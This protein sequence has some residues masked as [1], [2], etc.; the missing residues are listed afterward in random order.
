[1]FYLGYMKKCTLLLVIFSMIHRSVTDQLDPPI[2]CK[3]DHNC[4]EFSNSLKNAFCHNGHCVCKTDKEIKN[5]SSADILHNR[6][7]SAGAPIFQICKIDKDCKINNSFCNTTIMQCECQKNYILSSNKKV[8][9]KKAEGLD[10][11]CIEN[12]QCLTFLPNTTCKNNQCSC[13]SGY[14]Y[15]QNACYEM[16]D[17]GKPCRQ[18]E[19]CIHVNGAACTNRGVCDCIKETVINEDRQKCLPVA[20][21]ILDICVEDIQCTKTFSDSLC[22]DG[23][24]QCQN[25]YHFESEIRQCYFNKKLGETCANTYECYQ[26]EENENVTRKALRCMENVCVCIEDYVRQDDKCVNGGSRFDILP[27]LLITI[28][29]IVLFREN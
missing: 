22:I 3:E 2:P 15:V 29:S 19:E 12:R 9:L 14:H 6:N 23:L 8:C 20:R 18:S 26:N 16:I 7:R 17:I 28:V 13:I 1:M 11:P 5:C 21:D 4:I 25:Q 24:C 27:I 10:F